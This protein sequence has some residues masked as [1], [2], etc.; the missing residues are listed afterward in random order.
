MACAESMIIHEWAVQ[1][2]ENRTLEW[3]RGSTATGRKEEQGERAR[4][5][6]RTFREGKIKERKKGRKKTFYSRKCKKKKKKEE[7]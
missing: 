4:K 5:E 6:G 2:G 1:K 3:M 7:N